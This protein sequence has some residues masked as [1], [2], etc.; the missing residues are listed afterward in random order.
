MSAIHTPLRVGARWPGGAVDSPRSAADTSPGRGPKLQHRATRET[1]S[2]VSGRDIRDSV[3][4]TKV[5]RHCGERLAL[6]Q[7]T[8]HR[9]TRDRLS[10]WC[11][12]CHNARSA[13]WRAE[14]RELDNARRRERY[15][16]ARSGHAPASSEPVH[17]A[18][19]V[20]R[21]STASPSVGDLTPIPPGSLE[22]P[23]TPKPRPSV[24]ITYNGRGDR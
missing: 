23:N 16:A 15:R 3:S 19:N 6:D 8:R 14:N 12:S 7:Y 1:P 18:R 20:G 17:T 11:R 10:P 24:P 4:P 9:E 5:C 2:Q 22:S 21:G 13:Q